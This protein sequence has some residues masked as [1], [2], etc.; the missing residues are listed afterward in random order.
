M[1]A[2][3]EH[4]AKAA[5]LY[6]Q[7]P[8]TRAERLTWEQ[9]LAAGEERARAQF[10][11]GWFLYGTNYRSWFCLT[12]DDLAGGRAR[13]A[14]VRHSAA[15]DLAKLDALLPW[16]L[17]DGEQHAAVVAAHRALQQT[18]TELDRALEAL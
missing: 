13:L 1:S 11:H 9:F 6:L 7:A 16:R 3:E 5:R 8:T 15:S 4:G 12:D 14:S 18:L 10:R 2:A 17:A